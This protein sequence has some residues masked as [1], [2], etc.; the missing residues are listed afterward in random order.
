MCCPFVEHDRVGIPCIGPKLLY[1]G[2][3]IFVASGVLGCYLPPTRFLV[4]FVGVGVVMK[5]SLVILVTVDL[6]LITCLEG[7]LI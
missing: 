3:P 7:H 5:T 1:G 6:L 2:G 4:S